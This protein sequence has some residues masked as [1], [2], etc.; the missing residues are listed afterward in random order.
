VNV[1]TQGLVSYLSTDDHKLV[2]LNV[3]FRFAPAFSISEPITKLTYIFT[4]TLYVSHYETIK[5][6]INPKLTRMN[7]KLSRNY[8]SQNG[9]T[10]FV[11]TVKGS[12]AQMEAYKEAQGDNYRESEEGEA[13]WFTTRC[14]GDRGKLVITSKGKIVPDMSA[15]EQAASLSAQFGGNFGAELAKASVANLM[16]TSK[17]AEE[18][19]KAPA[20]E[21]KAPF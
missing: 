10:V 1:D 19:D 15:Y 7:V 18:A 17:V 8:R 14:I 4:Y 13:L 21:D 5:L 2:K 11:Y 3:G 6:F 16:G 12:V 20:G 9:N